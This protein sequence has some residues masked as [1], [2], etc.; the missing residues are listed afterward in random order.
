VDLAGVFTGKLSL[1]RLGVLID[2]LPP[3]S[4]TR[5]A[6]RD[7]MTPEQVA[8]L[9]ARE[10][11]GPWSLADHLLARVGDG[12]DWL[13]WAKSD[14]AAEKPRPFPRPGVKRDNVRAINP[15]ADAYLAN[16]RQRHREGA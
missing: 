5:T 9:P 13:V 16:L 11:D 8:A 7:S 4:A 10:G 12:I 1:R 15:A 2:H 14:Q 3:E 6:L